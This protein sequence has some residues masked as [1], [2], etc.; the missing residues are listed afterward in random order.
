MQNDYYLIIRFEFPNIKE[1]KLIFDPITE[2]GLAFRRFLWLEIKYVFQG[3]L[4]ELLLVRTQ[5]LYQPLHRLLR[6]A[7]LGYS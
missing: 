7:R 2:Q 5:L 6:Q 4:Q 1:K 3:H